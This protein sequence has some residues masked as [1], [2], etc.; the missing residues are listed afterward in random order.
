MCR[1]EL[2]DVRQ[3][4]S[5]RQSPKRSTD[6]AGVDFVLLLELRPPGERIALPLLV[7][8]FHFVIVVPSRIS[9]I[10]SASHQQAKF[11]CPGREEVICA[12]LALIKPPRAPHIS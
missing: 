9:R 7:D 10:V 1:L 8:G 12:P 3:M 6:S 5:S 2:S 4:T 11:I